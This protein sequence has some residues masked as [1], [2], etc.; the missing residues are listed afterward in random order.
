MGVQSTTNH[1]AKRLEVTEDLLQKGMNLMMRV[2]NN[3]II[4][5]KMVKLIDPT[6][7]VPCID[8]EKVRERDLEFEKVELFQIGDNAA[9]NVDY[10]SLSYISPYI[11]YFDGYYFRTN[12]QVRIDF[13]DKYTLS[14]VCTDGN[15]FYRH[16]DFEMKLHNILMHKGDYAFK[17][18]AKYE[19]KV[20]LDSSEKDVYLINESIDLTKWISLKDLIKENGGLLRIPFLTRTKAVIYIIKYWAQQI[21]KIM[22]EVQKLGCVLLLMR[23]ENI[24]ISKDGQKVKFK[25]FRGS[26]KLNEFGKV[27]LAPDFY[28]NLFDPDVKVNPENNTTHKVENDVNEKIFSDPYLAPEM[29]FNKIQDLDQN[30]DSWVFGCLL[31]HIL[32]GQPPK[33]FY[34]E[35][36]KV[37]P[38]IK[39]DLRS[40]AH[41]SDYFF[42]DIF[43][44]TLIN[45]ILYGD[46][47]VFNAEEAP[48]RMIDCI[49][50]KSY[51]AF[52][53]NII[54]QK[55]I[56][57]EEFN[58]NNKEHLNRIG[59]YLD[60]IASCLEFSPSKRPTIQSLYHCPVFQLDKYEDMI[61]KQFSEIMIFYK[62]PTLTIRDKVLVPLRK[63]CAQIIETPKK[64][65]SLENEILRIM[66]IV[67]WSIIEKKPKPV[68]DLK[69]TATTRFNLESSASK[70]GASMTSN[71]SNKDSEAEK[72]VEAEKGRA[73][74]QLLVKFIFSNYILD[75][76]V[77]LAL[78]H[79]TKSRKYLKKRKSKIERNYDDTVR[80][81]KGLL[82]IFKSIIFDMTSY[83]T[84]CS[85]YVQNF[86]E[87]FVKFLLGEEFKLT[88]DIAD[89]LSGN[90]ELNVI[91][92]TYDEYS[93]LKV[94]LGDS[95]FRSPE[96]LNRDDADREWKKRFASRP[97]IFS[98]SHWT[99]DLYHIVGPIYK[100]SVSEAGSGSVEYP[101]IQDYIRFETE[102]NRNFDFDMEN[103]MSFMNHK[104]TTYFRRTV[105][106]YN[107][108]M[109]ITENLQILY[110]ADARAKS[111]IRV[112]L[113][114]LK[115]LLQS[116]NTDKI[117]LL[118]DSK[119]LV[120]A[121]KYLSM[122]DVHIK[123]ELLEMLY[124]I[125]K[126]FEREPL[127]L[128]TQEKNEAL[129]TVEE[130]LKTVG[131]ISQLKES[132][133]KDKNTKD[134]L[135]TYSYD[136]YAFNKKI[137]SKY[138]QQLG[139]IYE[140]PVVMTYLTAVVKTQAEL[141]HNKK[142][143]IKIFENISNGPISVIKALN[144]SSIDT[145]SSICKIFIT[146]RKGIEIKQNAVLAPLLVD[147]FKKI[148]SDCRPEFINYLNH[149]PGTRV[150]LKE[151]G[152]D[153]PP[154]LNL[155]LLYEKYS[156]LADYFARYRERLVQEVQGGIV[157]S[158]LGTMNHNT[159]ILLKFNSLI[160]ENNTTILSWLT[161][162]YKRKEGGVVYVDVKKYFDKAIDLY[163]DIFDYLLDY[164][165]LNNVCG[166]II[167]QIGYL[168]ESIGVTEF[169]YIFVTTKDMDRAARTLNWLLDKVFYFFNFYAGLDLN[170]RE[171]ELKERED[172]LRATQSFGR[173][174]KMMILNNIL[175]K[176]SL[177]R[178]GEN[179]LNPTYKAFLRI[180]YF[181]TSLNN[182]EYN[183]LLRKIDFGKYFVEILRAQYHI[184]SSIIHTGT[185]NIHLIVNYAE[186]SQ[187]RLKTL[188]R[189]LLISDNSIKEEFIKTGI[190]HDL[191]NKYL[192]SYDQ[193]DV[194]T[195][196]LTF[197]FLP[198][199]N[200]LPIRNEALAIV[201]MITQHREKCPSVYS[202]L[203]L[204]LTRYSNLRNEY[205]N[206]RKY[207]K[208]LITT[209]SLY[210]FTIIL[211]MNDPQITHI[212]KQDNVLNYLKDLI[213]KSSELQHYYSDLA[214]QLEYA[215]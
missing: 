71:F 187:I 12:S 123:T 149:I 66:E 107:D 111:N 23:P 26:G 163:I 8:R 75:I 115:A 81:V 139:L 55:N 18:L 30:V 127:S 179:R 201:S 213:S 135:I 161:H 69:K 169:Y 147:A 117:K 211:Q 136:Y 6:Q 7:N 180:F 129:R 157:A 3:F 63:I 177:K 173:E 52:F 22:L 61:S 76:L 5:D 124:E 164:A 99:P 116:N 24:Y 112:S 67:N 200:F 11:K 215:A 110:Q 185:E 64:I 77:F 90:Q 97:Y 20:G 109:H 92:N 85:P 153:V 203:I 192:K 100:E 190:V 29:I 132:R 145:I 150:F 73:N 141:L 194:S 212:L 126:G 25:S 210:F 16:L 17:Y 65:I 37:Y 184:I 152:L 188:E 144:Y 134:K 204:A 83:Q 39:K 128:I 89:L 79:H 197:K 125:S 4:N 15:Q 178:Y 1:L 95:L 168:F 146:S 160:S 133:V 96:D 159:D 195:Y 137:N 32:F 78:R 56:L 45:D 53:A 122:E 158:Q 166:D 38:Q 206:L 174:K 9:F 118:L 35:I 162:Y 46:H 33:S 14:L 40:F 167:N 151:Q 205:E 105:D 104:T 108:I 191:C 10:D 199:R 182:P 21:L 181:L 186:E 175:N 148:L 91:R 68:E 119:I 142:L 47:E 44:D 2:A 34:E 51:E 94:D 58:K 196:K 140:S 36:L 57:N 171:N 113:Q 183:T 48:R 28:I 27:S 214:K 131:V 193:L 49:G 207:K 98:E 43:P 155:T 209:S 120:S 101:V 62:S 19:K 70:F 50:H 87:N 103:R 60:L 106:Y 114:Y 138:I 208:G 84:S 121:M 198:F 80:L 72:L 130:N 42:H 82:E 31:Y 86:L 143:V 172:E 59:C 93:S 102:N 74:N 165:Q 41:P 202:D 54:P 156:N 154:K 189:L 88:S 176:Q 13:Y 170:E